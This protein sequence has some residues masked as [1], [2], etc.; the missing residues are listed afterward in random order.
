MGASLAVG[1][2]PMLFGL[3]CVVLALFTGWLGGGVFKRQARSALPRAV[4]GPTIRAFVQ[5]AEVGGK[6]GGRSAKNTTRSQR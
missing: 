5:H 6:S 1:Q 3:A 2:F 4:V